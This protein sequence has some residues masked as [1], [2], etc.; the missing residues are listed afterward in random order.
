LEN[1]VS[2][3]K[4]LVMIFGAMQDKDLPGIME[5]LFSCASQV[6]VTRAETPRAADPVIRESLARG[7]SA[8][9]LRAPNLSAALSAARC[10][11]G[12]EDVIRVTGS[13][14][15]VGDVKSLLEGVEPRS[16]PA[17]YTL[18]HSLR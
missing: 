8:S 13:L 2:E 3:G 14:Y 5:P 17:L 11:A 16:R 4:K 18:R 6:I 15:L 9:V 12:P 10:E 1:Y 7:Y